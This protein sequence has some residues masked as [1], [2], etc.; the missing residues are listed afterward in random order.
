MTTSPFATYVRSFKAAALAIAIG[1]GAA[2][3][4]QA[5]QEAPPGGW[6]FEVA[7][8]KPNNSGDGRVMMQN[9]PGRFT[10]TNITLKLL[11]RNAYQ[12]QAFQITGGPAWIGSDHFDLVAKMPD[13]FQMPPGPPAPGSGPGPLQVMMRALLA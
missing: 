3:A 11:I 4:A 10:A 8:I 2:L 13:G 7:S 12:L 1:G 5:P 6:A 9:Q